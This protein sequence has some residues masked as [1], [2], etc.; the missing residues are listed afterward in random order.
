MSQRLTDIFTET[1]ERVVEQGFNC[2]PGLDFDAPRPG[3][4]PGNLWDPPSSWQD[5]TPRGDIG[6]PPER[7]EDH[8][9]KREML[10]SFVP[11]DY[12]ELNPDLAG[13]VSAE[14][15]MEHF[16]E[17]GYAERRPYSRQVW[18]SV[19]ANAYAKQIKARFLGELRLRQHY[20][21]KGRFEDRYPNDLTTFVAGT[22]IHLWQMGKVGSLSI[23]RAVRDHCGEHS[24][25]LHYVDAWHRNQPSIGVHYSRLLTRHGDRPKLVICGIRDPVDRVISGFFQE[26]ES[27][28]VGPE[29]L[30]DLESVMRRLAGRFLHDLWITCRWFEHN[31]F[32]G[33]D[34]YSIPFDHRSGY[35]RHE[36]GPVKLFLY[37]QKKLPHLESE[38]RDFLGARDLRLLRS[39]DSAEKPYSRS[40]AAIRDSISISQ[41]L[42]DR[43]RACRY[44]GHFFPEFSGCIGQAEC[45]KAIRSDG[46]AHSAT[47]TRSVN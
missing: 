40:L 39:N 36:T 14:D 1:I 30:G 13:S 11:C 38:L 33:L 25:H 31:F 7:L 26:A 4:A 43:V 23:Q 21:Y 28:G 34:V 32:C 47:R 17:R 46:N 12:I 44:V 41:S 29:D 15:A 3:I 8:P 42:I 37:T 20:A 35:I 6:D 5:P 16:V 24:A 2:P 9:Y 22:K 10:E 45:V 18:E 19:Q 27:S